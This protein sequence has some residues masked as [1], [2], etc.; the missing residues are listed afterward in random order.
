M[1]AKDV[2]MRWGYSP[3]VVRGTRRLHS[4]PAPWGFLRRG[5]DDDEEDAPQMA[6]SGIL[7][8]VTGV[9]MVA[10]ELSRRGFIA[11]ITF[12]NTEG[13][14]ILASDPKASRP[15][16][17]QVK[18]AQN[19]KR[20]WVLNQHAQGYHA[21][22]LFYVFVDLKRT[23]GRA[24][25][26]VVP[27]SVVAAFIADFHRDWLKKPSRSGRPHPGHNLSDVQGPRWEISE[28]LGLVGRRE[29]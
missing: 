18:T 27:S 11:S 20:T 3:S 9:Y 19:R 10:A 14:D 21:P 8:G 1:G 29:T 13:I 26:F 16:G 6:L 17:I 4:Y 25:F 15:V 7:S 28:P 12:R 22:N 2:Q 24:D 23:D 5:I